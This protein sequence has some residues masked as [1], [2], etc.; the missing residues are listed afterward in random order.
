MVVRKLL[1]LDKT[2]LKMHLHRLQGEDRRLRFGAV[3]TDSI[4]DSYV[5]SSMNDAWFGVYHIDGRIVAACHVAIANEEAELGCSVDSD[6]RGNGIAQL[7]FDRAVT[8]LRTRGI[9]T[10]YMHCLTENEAMRHIA[11]KN[12]MSIVSSYGE[13]DATVS[14]EPPTPATCFKDAYLDRLALYDTLFSNNLKLFN[15]TFWVNDES[16]TGN[17]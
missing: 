8:Y 2:K 4:I 17:Q 15:A 7:M 3:V 1:P 11:R 16:K 9:E 10:V 13:S 6:F 12:E 14:L 5:D